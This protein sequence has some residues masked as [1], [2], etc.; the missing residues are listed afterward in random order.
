VVLAPE[1]LSR[2]YKSIPS[3]PG[4]ERR[5]QEPNALMMRVEDQE[6]CISNDRF[7]KVVHFAECSSHEED[8][9]AANGRPVP[10]AVVHL[11]SARPKPHN[12][13][14]GFA[15]DIAPLEKAAPG[16]DRLLSPEA[17]HVRDKFQKI[18]FGG[19]QAPVEPG[20]LVVLAIGVVIAALR[21][22]EFI[23]PA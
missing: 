9:E 13:S 14:D 23:A 22:A 16:E 21:S 20:D 18:R 4:F 6:K 11:L 10:G 19:I 1:P 8:A 7:T 5:Q 2:V 12:V 15:A 3:L 17:D